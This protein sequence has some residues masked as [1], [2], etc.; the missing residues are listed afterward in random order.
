MKKNKGQLLVCG[1]PGKDSTHTQHFYT[2]TLHRKHK[3][4][5]KNGKGSRLAS[6]RESASTTPFPSS[7]SIVEASS[8]GF[9]GGGRLLRHTLSWGEQRRVLVKVEEE[10]RILYRLEHTLETC[11]LY[12]EQHFRTLRLLDAA[13]WCAPR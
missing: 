2:H 6:V 1:I 10:G 5:T 4:G 3:E 11:V 8:R 9:R 12:L 13:R 7:L